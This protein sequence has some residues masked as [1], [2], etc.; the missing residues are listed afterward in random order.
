MEKSRVLNRED[1][2]LVVIDVQERLVP[3]IDKGL[4]ERALRN[5]TIAIETAG[6]LGLPILL[7]EQYPKGLDAPSRTSWRRW[8]GNGTNCWKR[9]PSVAPATSASCPR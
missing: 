8:K 1:A 7:S 2:V 9:S 4:Y 6:T 3:A 5:T